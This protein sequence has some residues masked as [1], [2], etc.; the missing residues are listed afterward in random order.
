[1]MTLQELLP[2]IRELSEAEKRELWALLDRELQTLE[3]QHEP[4]TMSE[5]RFVELCDRRFGHLEPLEL[6]IPPREP[7]RLDDTLF[8]EF[9]EE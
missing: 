5:A 1:M 2:T 6:D 9:D 8:A 7:A 4:D 3:R